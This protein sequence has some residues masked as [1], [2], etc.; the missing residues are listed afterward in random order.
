[1]FCDGQCQK[2]KKKCGLYVEYLMKEASTGK[3]VVVKKCAI[4][5]LVA[6]QHRQEAGADRLHTA[7]NDQ[8]N[9]EVNTGQEISNVLANVGLVV[10]NAVEGSRKSLANFK[11][12]KQISEGGTTDG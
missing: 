10:H 8:R 7:I 1:M 9:E 6:S 5:E 4:H 3:D 12:L 2:G 11:E